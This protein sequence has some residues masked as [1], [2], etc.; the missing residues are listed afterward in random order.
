M[1]PAANTHHVEPFP[2]EED[3]P[4]RLEL[5][6]LPGK[7]DSS[8]LMEASSSSPVIPLE[9]AEPPTTLILF[10]MACFLAIENYVEKPDRTVLLA[11]M[12]AGP[13]Q[14]KCR[15]EFYRC[16]RAFKT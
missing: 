7:V 6:L 5:F 9:L 12:R 8:L 15:C 4:H 14:R 11:T 13:F 3:M 10:L 16:F 2:F 1:S